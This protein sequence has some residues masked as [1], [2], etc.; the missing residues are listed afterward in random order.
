MGPFYFTISTIAVALYGADKL[1]AKAGQRRIPE[2]MLL[3]VSLL[4]GCFGAIPAMMI[5]RHKIRK[6]KFWA[7]NLIFCGLHI[8]IILLALT[9]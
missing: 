1:M 7:G 2:R 3:F 5:F 6:P 9:R 8:I 4:G